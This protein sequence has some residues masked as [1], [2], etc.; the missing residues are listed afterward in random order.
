MNKKT[1]ATSPMFATIVPYK[2]VKN[3]IA[4]DKTKTARSNILCFFKA[5]DFRVTY[6][7]IVYL[8]RF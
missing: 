5:A 1:S 4:T 8:I 6:C 7:I 3:K 2:E